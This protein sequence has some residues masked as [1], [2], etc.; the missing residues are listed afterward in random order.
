MAGRDDSQ[1]LEK[2]ILERISKL[3]GL[4]GDAFRSAAGTGM[5]AD[6]ERERIASL[7]RSANPGPLADAA[8]KRVFLEILSGAHAA[9]ASVTVAFLGPEGTQS[10]VA[11]KELFGESIVS[12]PQRTIQDVFREV[13]KEAALYGVVPIE[14]STEGSVTYTLDELIETNLVIQAEQYV[15]ITYSLLSREK[16]S[17]R[18]PQGVQPPAAPWA[19]ARDGSRPISRTRRR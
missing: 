12:L 14:N 4:Y 16:E 10:H 11:V 3:A 6:G 13:E 2:E 7:V 17:R 5:F 18:G 1:R 15:R 19:S 8:V 9:A